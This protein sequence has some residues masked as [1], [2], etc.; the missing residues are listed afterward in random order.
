MSQVVVSADD[1]GISEVVNNA[2]VSCFKNGSISMTSAVMNVANPSYLFELAKQ[3][4]FEN[5]VGLHIN[6]C[7]GIPLTNNIK[8]IRHFCDEGGTFNNRFL[9][10][11][12][13][14]FFLSKFEKKAIEKEVI[15]QIESFIKAG[16]TFMNI[17]SHRHYHNY[18][19]LFRIIYKI[20]KKYDFK[21]MRLLRCTT[22]NPIKR[23]YI[24]AKNNLIK[25]NL[26][27]TDAFYSAKDY[28]ENASKNM[29]IIEIM[30]HP[31][32]NE[33]KQL[34][35][36]RSYSFVDINNSIVRKGDAIY[37]V[38]NYLWKA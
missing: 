5:R 9:K 26:H 36:L 6:L 7:E 38:K 4:N 35:N 22:K 23:I 21:S 15:A 11:K 24:K 31:S 34:I 17:D 1:Y 14:K 37:H 20:A 25:K 3:N 30:T 33:K 27:F 8:L 29:K 16:F 13:K 18:P 2:I 19:S 32:L 10:S 12:V 28:V